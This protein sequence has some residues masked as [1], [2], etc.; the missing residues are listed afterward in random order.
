[1]TLELRKKTTAELT[2]LGYDVIPSEANFFMVHIRRPVRSVTKPFRQR[3]V[4][5]GR[6]FPPMDDYLRVTVGNADEMARFMTAF[7]EIVVAG[8]DVAV[9]PA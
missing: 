9:K 8:N 3:G 7:K 2:S 6:P 5:V 4:L 1:M